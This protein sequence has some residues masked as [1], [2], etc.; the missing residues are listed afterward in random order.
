MGTYTR[1]AGDIMLKLHTEIWHPQNNATIVFLHGFTGSTK[2]W[3]EVIAALPTNYRY[4]AVDLAGH[5]ATPTTNELAHYTMQTQITA[6]NHMLNDLAVKQFSLVGYSMGG[7]TALSYALQNS[8]RVQTLLLESASPGLASEAQR[9]E[10]IARDNALAD[11]IEAEG[12]T[13][14]VDFWQDIPLFATQKNLSVARQKAI[15]DERLQQNPQ[16][17]ANSLRGMGTGQQP[18]LWHELDDFTVPTILV[19]G[20]Y[21]KKFIAIG[22]RML[23]RLPNAK[24]L[25]V[26]EAGHAI[27]V[28]NPVQ[29]ATIVKEQL[30]LTG[31]KN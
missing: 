14:F 19:T 27:H 5:G 9:D 1:R 26:N 28:E 11:R 22:E 23:E 30:N 10:R 17:L 4:I 13:A 16:G 6:L 24:Q 15:R 7:R 21:D 3:H 18:S 29:F 31:G 2:T 8:E 25:I 20:A 12:I